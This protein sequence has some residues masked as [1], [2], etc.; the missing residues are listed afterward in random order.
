ME[1]HDNCE[2]LVALIIKISLIES[3]LSKISLHKIGLHISRTIL[4]LDGDSKNNYNNNNSGVGPKHVPV[5]R[6]K[7]L[8]V[9]SQ[10]PFGNFGGVE[11]DLW[12]LA[13]LEVGLC[14]ILKGVK[15]VLIFNLPAYN[16]HTDY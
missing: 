13:L 14:L 5:Y 2:G 7:K 8:G 6:G 12:P 10:D 16:G 4:A 1:P 9:Q 3:A 15:I 11:D